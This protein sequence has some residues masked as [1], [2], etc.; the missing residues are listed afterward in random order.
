[1]TKAVILIAIDTIL[2]LCIC[3]ICWS[4]GSNVTLRYHDLNLKAD[5]KGLP[6]ARLTSKESIMTATVLD[7]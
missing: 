6:V 5:A 3:Y 1:M 2:Q 4:M 7:H